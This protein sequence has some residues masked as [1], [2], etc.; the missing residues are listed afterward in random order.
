MSYVS[1][2]S[3]VILSRLFGTCGRMLLYSPSDRNRPRTSWNTKM[4]P[5]RSNASLGPSRSL[6][7]SDPYGA[8]EYGVRTSRIGW[9][10][11]SFGT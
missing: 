9:V 11:P 2:L 1:V 4:S 8:T 7:R 3:S 5:A 6:Y 10:L